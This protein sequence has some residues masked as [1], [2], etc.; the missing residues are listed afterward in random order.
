M[1]NYFAENNG[2]VSIGD[3]IGMMEKSINSREVTI[4]MI[5]NQAKRILESKMEK[6]DD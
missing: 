4:E 1:T 2:N 3:L 6:L 5:E